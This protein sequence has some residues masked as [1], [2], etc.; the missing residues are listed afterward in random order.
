MKTILKI[1]VLFCCLF[2][3]AACS[4]EDDV[5]YTEP[6]VIVSYKTVGGIWQLSEWNGTPLADGQYCYIV[7]NRTEHTFTMYQNFDSQVSR[8]I[9]GSFILDKDK[10]QNNR[11][12]ISGEYDYNNGDW[13]D[14]Y[15]ITIYG[16]DNPRMV[17]VASENSE[18]VSVYRPCDEVPA[19][20]VAGSRVL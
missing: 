1:M 18:D 14:D 3:S 6:T 2:G 11:D 8:K 13:N 10:E 9:T 12:Y 19:D 16:G 15:Y 17:W 4:N 20:I 5:E 7:M